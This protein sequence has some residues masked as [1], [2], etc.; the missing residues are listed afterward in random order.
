MVRRYLLPI[1]SL[2]IA[3]FITPQAFAQSQAR[4]PEQ[5]VLMKEIERI[6]DSDIDSCKLLL[7]SLELLFEEHE[8]APF[9]WFVPYFN[10]LV[11]SNLDNEQDA[12]YLYQEALQEAEEHSGQNQINS[13]SLKL[14]ATH[15]R[16]G[17]DSLGLAIL[18]RVSFDDAKSD[19]EEIYQRAYALFV[20]GNYHRRVGMDSL[21]IRDLT[22][23]LALAERIDEGNMQGAMAYT[24]A[25]IYKGIGEYEQSF[26]YYEAALTAYGPKHVNLCQTYRA[27]AG[28]CNEAGYPDRALELM[29]TVSKQAVLSDREKVYNINTL[30]GILI[31]L[32]RPSE[33]LPH[34]E[35]GLRLVNGIDG[36]EAKRFQLH[37]N[38]ANA[39]KALGQYE[40]A[41]FH[42]GQALQTYRDADIDNIDHHSLILEGFLDARLKQNGDEKMAT[43]FET[44]VELRD[45]LFE[46]ER[47]SVNADLLEKYETEQRE[48]EIELLK[49]QDENSQLQIASQ[50]KILVLSSLVALLTALGALFFWRQRQRTNA[51]ND[52][53]LEKNQQVQRLNSEINHRVKNQLVLASNLLKQQ[54]TRASNLEAR[55]IAEASEKNLRAIASV[56]RRLSEVN[57]YEY[58]DIA[59][60]LDEIIEDIKFSMSEIDN[61][62]IRYEHKFESIE[63]RQDK[64]I[65]LALIMN[66]LLTNSVK[67]AFGREPNPKIEVELSVQDNQ[68]VLEY[69]DN[70]SFVQDDGD[71]SGSQLIHSFV[72]QLQA[73]LVNLTQESMSLKISFPY[74]S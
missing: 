60:V 27:W 25:N 26:E 29:N 55:E 19:R 30:A 61:K 41:T 48:Q 20:M 70:G 12:L 36:L 71:G 1:A 68:L 37:G 52:Q 56:N 38:K 72:E 69:Q 17:N 8:V 11:Q 21:A 15:L 66:E 10:G 57:D 33:A 28:A 4:T 32:N 63:L 42:Y 53:L 9:R 3:V 51:L 59:A 23:A 54:K 24:I 34:L 2:L 5:K 74:G 64:A 14:G 46:L 58:V 50:K 6:I 44:Y 31:D 49:V 43:N 16:L 45:S 47:L 65:Y 73:K 35:E 7:D 39:H 62:A 67:H 18:E 40:K 13:I 22:E